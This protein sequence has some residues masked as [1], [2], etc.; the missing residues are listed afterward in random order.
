MTVKL[1]DSFF[2]LPLSFSITNHGATSTLAQGQVSVT[3]PQTGQASP[4]TSYT[5]YPDLVLPGATRQLRLSN[6]ATTLDQLVDPQAEPI[7]NL[8]DFQDQFLFGSYTVT[9]QLTSG[10]HLNQTS[11]LTQTYTI[12]FFPIYLGGALL[13]TSLILF[14]VF[15]GQKVNRH[16]KIA[17]VKAPLRTKTKRRK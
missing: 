11:P 17:R 1:V 7:F 9:A 4:T 2:G 6:S 5:F 3:P 12:F 8:P 10:H 14:V 16:Q 13:L 15:L